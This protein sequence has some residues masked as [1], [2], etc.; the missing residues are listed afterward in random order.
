MYP[1]PI[2][3]KQVRYNAA[4]Q[5]FEAAVT[6]HDNDTVR[7]YAC[8]IKAP[9]SMTYEEASRRLGKQAIHNHQRR[10]GLFSEVTRLVQGGRS[11]T[12]G[13]WF[14]DLL[15]VSGRKAA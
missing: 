13:R 15:Q 7:T 1:C 8:S 14:R 3:L 4:N 2:E 5:S 6:V 10:G 9:L 12:R 11:M